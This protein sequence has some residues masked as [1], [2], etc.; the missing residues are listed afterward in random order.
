MLNKETG[1]EHDSTRLN[2]AVDVVRTAI[3]FQR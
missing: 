1:N 3:M 2:D